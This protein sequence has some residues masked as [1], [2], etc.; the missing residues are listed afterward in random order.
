LLVTGKT[1]FDLDNMASNNA[2]AL[3]MIGGMRALK[4]VRGA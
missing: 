3:D 2:T 4:A 1:R